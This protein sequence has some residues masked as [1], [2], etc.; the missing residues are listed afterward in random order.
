MDRRHTRNYFPHERAFPQK[1]LRQR[2]TTSKISWRL[3]PSRR[4]LSVYGLL[5]LLGLFALS[6]ALLYL[7]FPWTALPSYRDRKVNFKLVTDVAVPSQ[8][9][10]GTNLLILVTSAPSHF[11][12]REAIRA[13]WANRESLRARRQPF[14]GVN[15]WK[16][17]FMLGK[18][19]NASIN[20]RVQREV[21]E[22]NDIL[23]GEF[24]D[25]YAHLVIK[26]MM[27]L[28]W[29]SRVNCTHVLKADDDVYVHIPRLITWL[30]QPSLPARL[31]AGYAR[32]G[33]RVV[34]RTTSKFFLDL[35][36]YPDP[37][38]PPYCT[39]PFYVLSR[40]ILPAL[41]N[42]T[43]LIKPI[44]I[45]DAY[46]GMLTQALG[47]ALVDSSEDFEVLSRESHALRLDDCRL[48]SIVC[49]GHGISPSGLHTI[50]AR[51]LAIESLPR[52]QKDLICI[53]DQLIFITEI[54]CLAS[55][56]VV[57]LFF[58]ARRL[59][60]LLRSLLSSRLNMNS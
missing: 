25:S 38:F 2:N 29:A 30:R 26:T 54:L 19:S 60:A 46:I 15:D 50:H 37:Y 23:V 31:Y 32:I 5:F 22:F 4:N 7:F 13:T 57:V 47:V 45:E 55:V 53:R 41:V 21:A 3:N 16:I 8:S 12:R 39:G 51:H 17:V 1:Y 9:F 24:Q 33:V 14:S 48:M 59:L 52:E 42:L 40:N 35:E 6:F 10:N 49:L 43:R 18:T 20:A 34:R 58:C 27:G 28:S 44:P 36:S 11:Q 56:I